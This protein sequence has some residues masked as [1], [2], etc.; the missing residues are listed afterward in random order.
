MPFKN[1]LL[2]KREK[3][4][5]FFFI[6]YGFLNLGD[7]FFI[8]KCSMPKLDRDRKGKTF[9]LLFLSTSTNSI[10]FI[11]Y[12]IIQPRDIDLNT[13]RDIGI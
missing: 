2:E 3:K 7:I 1:L 5:Q 12:G 6:R 13:G 4:I 11:L 10:R 8:S 9:V